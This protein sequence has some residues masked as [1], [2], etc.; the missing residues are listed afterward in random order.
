LIAVLSKTKFGN[1]PGCLREKN[2]ASVFCGLKSTSQ[3]FAQ[4]EIS[5]RSWF[6]IPSTSFRE[7]AE[8]CRELSSAKSL[9]RLNSESEISLTYIKNMRGP[10]TDPWGTPA[11]IFFDVEIVDLNVTL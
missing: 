2:S 8:Q 1:N 7:V 11:V 4:S 9:V 6:R 3:I 10:N 5:L